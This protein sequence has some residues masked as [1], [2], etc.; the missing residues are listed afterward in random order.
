[1]ID[2]PSFLRTLKQEGIGFYSG[3][4][5]SLLG[6]LFS[7]LEKDPSYVSA[8]IEGEALA[9]AAG[10]WCAGQSTAVFLQNSGLGNLVNG[11]TSLNTPFGIPTLLFIGWRG[12]PGIPDEPQHETMGQISTQL[13]DLM[14]VPWWHLSQEPDTA[15]QQLHEARIRMQRDNKPVAILVSKNTFSAGTKAERTIPQKTRSPENIHLQTRVHDALLSRYEALEVLRTY[16]PGTSGIVATTGKCGR[17][18]FTV[19]DQPAHL[20]MVGAMG[21]ASAVALGAALHT[22]KPILVIDGDGAALMR[23]GTMAVIGAQ[24]PGNLLHIILDNGCHES[25]GAQP[26][27]A[28]ETDFCSIASACGYVAVQSCVDRKQIKCALEA[29]LETGGPSLIHIP[30]K[31]GSAAHLTR[32]T[33]SPFA[34][35][36]RF[37]NYLCP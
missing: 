33:V 9:I 28:P 24:A 20:Y 15:A 32:P 12:E 17:E 26:T 1:M 18:L 8:S 3:V 21:S 31:T 19:G 7:E 36:R 6:G 10:A 34:V 25:T 16:A 2:A 30:V 23:L 22:D 5:C 29:F 13:L 14:D 11:I 37:Q 35:A 4:P 27:G